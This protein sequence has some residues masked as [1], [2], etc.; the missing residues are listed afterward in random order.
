MKNNTK[1]RLHLSKQLFES[2]TKQ[3]IAEAKSDMSGGAYTEAVKTPKVKHDK[4]PKAHKAEEKPVKEMETK[5]A[6]EKN[7]MNEAAIPPELMQSLGDVI[8]FVK[9][10]AGYL[11]TIGGITGLSKLIASQVNKDPETRKA[12]D[13]ATGAGSMDVGAFGGKALG[14]GK[15]EV[16]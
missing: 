13:A 10:N 9:D 12:L 7:E 15:K 4:A 11:A 5:V 6:E 14:G 3:V 16:K 1:I 2:L 8:D